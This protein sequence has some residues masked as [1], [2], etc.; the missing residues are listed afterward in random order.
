M[1]PSRSAR[2]LIARSPTS[3]TAT[4][5]PIAAHGTGRQ[6][7]RAGRR[8][9]R[10]A[11][12]DR[13]AS[14][15]PVRFRGR[16][17]RARA[18][19]GALRATTRPAGVGSWPPP[20][21]RGS[22]AAP[23]RRSR[24]SIAPTASSATVGSAPT[25]SHLRGT[26]GLRCGVPADAATI[27]AAGAAEVSPVAPAKA[28]EMLV[29]AAQAAS[30]AGDAA[31]IVEFGRRAWRCSTTTIPTSASRSTSSSASAACS[32]VTRRVACRSCG[33][34]SPWPPASRI[35][36]A[37]C[38]PARAPAISATR[39]PSTSSTAA[40]PLAPVRRERWRCCRTSSSSWPAPRRWAGATRRPPPTPARD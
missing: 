21:M 4:R 15:A 34:L 3:S 27:L 10:G 12:A 31:Q 20:R 24:S 5:T 33:R 36:A 30:Y 25:S 40:R 6:P 7:R 32:P 13:A 38:T 28:I 8:R 18:R 14:A 9:G 1:R 16:C 23:S 22:P 37:W 11:R 35:P 29:E 26:I 2:P 17:T 19:G 39:R